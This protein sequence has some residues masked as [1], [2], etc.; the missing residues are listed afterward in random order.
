MDQKEVAT[1]AEGHITLVSARSG[2]QEKVKQKPKVKEKRN[3]MLIN[4]GTIS[5]QVSSRNNGGNGGLEK[6]EIRNRNL[7]KE[8]GRFRRAFMA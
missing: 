4:I 5:I 1:N 3:G 8:Q 7:E 2:R 6:E